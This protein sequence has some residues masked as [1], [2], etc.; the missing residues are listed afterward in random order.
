MADVMSAELIEYL[1]QDIRGRYVMEIKVW[2]VTDS[3][4]PFNLKYSLVFVERLTK[5]KV[6]MDNHHPKK[7]HVHLDERELPYQFIST[8]KL[9]DDFRNYIFQHFGEKL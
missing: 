4:Y 8:A 7:P 1:K 3:R 6:L 2:R 9:L 5:R